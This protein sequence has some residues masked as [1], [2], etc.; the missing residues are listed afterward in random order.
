LA[1]A[2]SKDGELVELEKSRKVQ[3]GWEGYVQ[4]RDGYVTLTI[5]SDASENSTQTT[6]AL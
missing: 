3:G 2:D 6:E 4:G 5:I 1:T